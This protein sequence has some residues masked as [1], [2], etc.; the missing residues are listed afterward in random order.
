MEAVLFVGAQGSGKTTFYRERRFAAHVRISLDVLRTRA[1][2]QALVA[3]CHRQR[4]PYVVDNTNATAEDRARYLVPARAAGFRVAAYFFETDLATALR[5]N[6]ARAGEQRIPRAGL[7][8]TF[9]RLRPPA[10]EEGFDELYVVRI[11]DTGAFVVSPAPR[12]A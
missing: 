2:E 9:K 5:R 11:E 6:E 12:A 4:R 7:V 3:A 8:A 1:R 10:W